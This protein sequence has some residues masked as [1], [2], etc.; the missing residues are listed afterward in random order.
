MKDDPAPAVTLDSTALE[1]RETAR[2]LAQLIEQTPD[3]VVIS[4][5]GIIL[6]ANPAAARMLGVPSAAQLVGESL[7][8]FVVPEDALLMRERMASV[9]RGENPGPPRVYRAVRPDG[10]LVMVEIASF[11]SEHSGQPAI[12]AFGRDVTD[13]EKLQEQLARTERLAALGTLAAG[14]AHE[15][16]NPLAALALNAEV[17]GRAM[18]RGHFSDGDR[19][20]GAMALAELRTSVERMTA[21]VRDL[22][23]FSRDSTEQFGAVNVACV[24]ERAV[25]VASHATRQR[26]SVRTELTAVPPVFGHAGKLE[27]VLLNLLVNA[28][29]AFPPDRGEAQNDIVV[30]A[31]SP[32]PLHVAIEVSDNG[33]G[34]PAAVAGRVFDPFFTTKPDG[35]GTGLGL[36]ISHNH[37]R[38]MEGELVLLDSGAGRGTTMRV[39]LRAAK[40]GAEQQAPESSVSRAGVRGRVL[41]VDDEPTMCRSLVSLLRERYDVSSAP[42]GAEALRAI[43]SGGPCD[44]I[45]CDLMMPGVTGMELFSLIAR[46]WPGLEQRMLF[47]TGGAFTGEARAFL[48]R[49]P[50]LRLQKPFSADELEAA[51]QQILQAR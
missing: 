46:E 34:I 12:I 6:E 38:Q 23:G 48:G 24:V 27:Q 19:E 31:F 39:V 50:N 9:A 22:T 28:A 49:C 42:G 1:V 13:R 10:T 20:T 32:D 2:R 26:A 17:L 15:I 16:N 37:V 30:R 35:E 11:A 8:R 40:A 21:V 33:A 29:Q 18:S 25:R 3:A 7:A 4:R 45:L 43:S 36:F 41:V 5:R 51:I 14:V 47:M 44:L